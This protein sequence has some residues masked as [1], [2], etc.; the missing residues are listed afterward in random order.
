MQ[1][2]NHGVFEF[3]MTLLNGTIPYLMK[4]Q[5]EKGYYQD[6]VFDYFVGGYPT[7][8]SVELGTYSFYNPDNAKH[9]VT[10]R[11]FEAFTNVTFQEDYTLRIF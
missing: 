10:G 6:I 9:N 3:N 7:T 4:I 5:A 11:L 1:V 8:Y 2:D